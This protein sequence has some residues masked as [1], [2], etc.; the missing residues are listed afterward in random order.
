MGFSFHIFIVLGYRGILCIM[1]VPNTPL[2]GPGSQG[3]TLRHVCPVYSLALPC[4]PAPIIHLLH[5]ICR[6]DFIFLYLSW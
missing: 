5:V 6:S 4:Q 1:C 2:H 3:Y